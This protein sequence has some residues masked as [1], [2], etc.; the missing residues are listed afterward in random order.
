MTLVRS[1][2]LPRRWNPVAH[3]RQTHAADPCSITPP[4]S[5]H[6]AS[7]SEPA[8]SIFETY[9]EIVD[10]CCQGWLRTAVQNSA[11][12]WSAPFALDISGRLF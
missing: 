11:A 4:A 1:W 2:S 7:Y 6:A 3:N 12:V 9:D 10:A 5:L 8:I